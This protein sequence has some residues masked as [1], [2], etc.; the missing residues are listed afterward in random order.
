MHRVERAAKGH[1]APRPGAL[2]ETRKFREKFCNRGLALRL[3]KGDDRQSVIF[4][5]NTPN[6]VVVPIGVD[7]SVSVY[8]GDTTNVIVDV[9]G[10]GD[11]SLNQYVPVVSPTRI[12][13]PSL[14]PG[15]KPASTAPSSVDVT[16]WVLVVF[17]RRPGICG[18]IRR[19]IRCLILRRI[20]SRRV[21]RG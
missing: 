1:N 15:A 11:D 20:I 14:V 6:H 12:Q 16:C 5:R 2:L 19:G 13:V 21:I 8:A 3:L 18:F 10:F 17:Q 4:G 9:N 7:G